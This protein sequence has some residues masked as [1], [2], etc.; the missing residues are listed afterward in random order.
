MVTYL[1]AEL[2]KG[3]SGVDAGLVAL[4]YQRRLVTTALLNVP[5]E[6]IVAHVGL[7]ADEPLNIHSGRLEVVPVPPQK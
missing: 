2:F 3:E 5:V 1:F 4:P 7:G 6:G